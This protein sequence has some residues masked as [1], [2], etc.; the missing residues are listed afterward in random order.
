RAR[1]LRPDEARA[2]VARLAKTTDAAPEALARLERALARGPI[3]D[4]RSYL[5]R[6]VRHA[7]TGASV[8]TR[9]DPEPPQATRDSLAQTNPRL[10]DGHLVGGYRAEPRN[11]HVRRGDARD[12]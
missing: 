10:F 3:A 2:A 9:L 6:I 7:N 11:G 8:T 5:E 4:P 12:N 1:R